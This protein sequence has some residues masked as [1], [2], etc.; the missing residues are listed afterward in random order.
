MLPAPKACSSGEEDGSTQLVE[1]SR[2]SGKREA[3]VGSGEE[4]E[5]ACVA[6]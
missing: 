5:C 3:H 1:G 4:A 6:E 2:A